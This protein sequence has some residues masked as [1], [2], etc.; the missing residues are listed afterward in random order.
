MA[1]A[2]AGCASRVP[3]PPYSAQPQSALVEVVAPPPPG[4]VEVVPA[5]PKTGAVW[6]DGEWTWRR[7]RWAWTAGRWVIAPAGAAFCPWVFE[8]GI[9]GRLWYAP[10]IWRD[11]TGAVVS[12]PEPIASAKVD[13]AAVVNASGVIEVIGVTARPGANDGQGSAPSSG[14][15]GS[16]AP[17]RAP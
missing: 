7:H 16:N 17:V 2:F 13:S 5:N 14:S 6:I 1:T 11:R 3:H 12:P 10:G 4:R 8:R 15:T 9:D